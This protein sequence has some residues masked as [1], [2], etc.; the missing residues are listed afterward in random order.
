MTEDRERLIEEYLGQE[1]DPGE[2]TKREKALLAPAGRYTTKPPLTFTPSIP[3][4][5]DNKDRFIMRFFGA[6]VMERDEM[7][8]QK[9]PDN[10]GK[11]VKVKTRVVREARF[12]FGMSPVTRYKA[13][14]SLD[15]MS[16]RYTEAKIAYK[17]AYGREAQTPDDIKQYLTKYAVVIRVIQ[18][19]VQRVDNEGNPVGPEPDREP[20]NLV[21]QISAVRES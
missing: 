1:D 5:G 9:D 14:G 7:V 21:V 10:E 16:A 18:T 12:G 6:A 3:D 8:E 17:Q 19:G 13:D 20:G 15:Y 2:Q 11:V 4:E